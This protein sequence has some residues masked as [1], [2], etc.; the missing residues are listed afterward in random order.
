MEATRIMMPGL[1][2]SLCGEDIPADSGVVSYNGKLSVKLCSRCLRIM[3]RA[4]DGVEMVE[5]TEVRGVFYAPG[6][7]PLPPPIMAA[8]RKVV[9]DAP[10]AEE[11]VAPEPLKYSPKIPPRRKPG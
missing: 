11:T 2:C 10:R 6:D 5:T 9:Y 1:K 7:A 4:H 8:Q 3:V